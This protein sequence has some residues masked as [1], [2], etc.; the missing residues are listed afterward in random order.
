MKIAE[1]KKIIKESL[2]DELRDSMR[3][4]MRDEL[5]DVKFLVEVLSESAVSKQQVI[6]NQP[7]RGSSALDKLKEVNGGI[8]ATPTPSTSGHPMLDML[9]ETAGTMTP[10]DRANSGVGEMR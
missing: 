8:F 4:I 5:K 7:E 9:A 10:T 3:D 6:Q 2:K 1:L